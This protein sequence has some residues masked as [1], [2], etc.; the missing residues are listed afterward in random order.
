MG[1]R[2][3]RACERGGGL[4]G[5]GAAARMGVGGPGGIAAIAAQGAGLGAFW[6][7]RDL[8]APVG[9]QGSPGMARASAR[10]IP[11]IRSLSQVPALW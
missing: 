6:L 10:D 7:I 11:V 9:S 8:R 3:G 4:L 2:R 1:R 5:R